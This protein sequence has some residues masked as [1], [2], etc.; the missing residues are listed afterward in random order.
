MLCY[1]IELHTFYQK[2]ENP[3]K[4]GKCKIKT[5][6]TTLRWEA[7]LHDSCAEQIL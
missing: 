1:N 3:K 6:H 4:G 2:G 7:N 5:R